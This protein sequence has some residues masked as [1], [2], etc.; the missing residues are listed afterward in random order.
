MI[1]TNVALT[2]AECTGLGGKVVNVFVGCL[3]TSK[4]CYTTGQDNV[5]RHAC[6]TK[7]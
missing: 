3:G 6:I 1:N 4:A 5:I 2:E 7:D